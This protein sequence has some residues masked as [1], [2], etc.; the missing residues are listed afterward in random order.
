MNKD[1]LR[2][3]VIVLLEA[4]HS[5]LLQAAKSAHD[6]ATHE[7]NIPDDKYETLALEASY[8]AQGQANRAQEIKQ[9]VQAFRGLALQTFS[10][11]VPIRLT[12]LVVLVDEEG[13]NRAVFLGPAA[14]GLRLEF[15]GEEVMVITPQSPLGQALIGRQCGDFVE[16]ESGTLR[17]YEIISVR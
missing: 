15:E 14:G 3:R 5:L 2:S 9:A 4:D 6:A 17:E 1:A 13:C 8:V 12:A 11:N 10:D 16:L 7:E